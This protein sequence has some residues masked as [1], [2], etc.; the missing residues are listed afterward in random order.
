[1]KN[2]LYLAILITFAL[3]S[4]NSEPDPFL[5]QKQNIG[6]LT[7]ST[8]VFDLKTVFAKDSVVTNKA[9]GFNSSP[10]VEIL[11]KATGKQLLLLTPIS[12]DSTATIE[13]VQIMD[14]RYKTEKGLNML[15]TFKDIDEN[16]TISS[17]DN[18]LRSVVISVKEIDASFTIDKEQLPGNVRFNMNSKIEASQIPDH[19]KIKYFMIHW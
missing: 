12:A 16:Y 2:T 11:D 8:K 18:L 3:V 1:M 5:I 9:N 19:A 6:H 13:V 14:A 7:D 17:I 15:S 4:C 10:T